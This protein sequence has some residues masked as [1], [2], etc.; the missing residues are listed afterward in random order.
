MGYYEQRGPEAGEQPPGCLEALVITRAVFGILLWPVIALAAVFLDI[1][2]TFYL[3][4]LHPA[5]ALIPIG[6]TA[7]LVALYA[8][9]EQRRARSGLPPDR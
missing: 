2:I 4:A 8:R 7:A 6:A 3:Y 1:G 5:L 9:W